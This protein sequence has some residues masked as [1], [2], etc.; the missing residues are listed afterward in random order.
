MER[1]FALR[2]FLIMIVG[3]VGGVCLIG[4]SIIRMDTQL[5]GTPGRFTAQLCESE[6]TRRGGVNWSC[7]G[8]FVADDKSFT[9][10]SAEMD[11]TFDSE[12]TAPVAAKAEG[13]DATTVVADDPKKWAIPGGTGVIIFGFGAFMLRG[14]LRDRKESRAAAAV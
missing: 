10:E 12:P 4:F 6:T 5:T 3:L 11:T 13:P 14:R 2:Q 1:L 9:L 8:S 7:T